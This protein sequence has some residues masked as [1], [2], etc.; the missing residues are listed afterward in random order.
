MYL[1]ERVD[2]EER[3]VGV[4]VRVV[5]NVEVDHLFDHVVLGASRL[6]EREVGGGW[7]VGGG[8]AVW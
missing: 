4:G 5:A 1:L 8:V 7:G 3:E 2:R 6:R